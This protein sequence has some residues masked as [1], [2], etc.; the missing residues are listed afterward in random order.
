MSKSSFPN[1]ATFAS[2][3]GQAVWLMTVSKAHRDLKISDIET[4]V[5][6]AI[7]LQQFKIFMKGKQPIAF[8]A[9]ASVS[10]E[11]KARF[12]KGSRQLEPNEW[13][14]GP[15]VVVVECVSPFAAADDIEQQFFQSLKSGAPRTSNV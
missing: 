3:M 10:N 13:R 14:S 7:L 6:P 15:N 4:Q 9:W 5:T 1:E 8:L 2:A 12:A 11:V